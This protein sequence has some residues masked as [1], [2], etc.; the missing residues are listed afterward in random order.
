MTT[1]HRTHIVMY[2]LIMLAWLIP[3]AFPVHAQL[4]PLLGGQRAGI[5]SLQFLK[6][7][8]GARAGAMAE[9]FVAVADDASALQY[10][11]AGLVQFS[12]H[13]IMFSH[14][15]WLV[16]LRHEFIGAVYRLSSADAI[17]VSFISLHTDD[18]E[19]TTET[20]PFGTGRYFSYG[21]IAF[22]L[23][24]SRALTEQFSFG[25]TVRYVE[26]SIDVLKT[27]AFMVDIGTFYRT[28]LGSTR[29]SVV[30]TNFGPNVAPE[31]VVQLPR[32]EELRSFQEFSPPTLFRI[33]FAFEA[34]QDDIN[35]I[36]TSLQ[37]N[38]P[39][40][41][42]E[43][44]ALGVEYAWNEIMH[45]RCGYKLNVDEEGL[46]AG[47]GVLAPVGGVTAGVDYAFAEFGRLGGVHRLTIRLG[48]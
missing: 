32:R 46:T 39:N 8:A 27:R 20:Q 44:L 33:G 43:N 16:D 15:N 31:G 26:E 4:I 6:I 30:V 25:A 40:D 36:T 12:G 37:L 38:H 28:G 41:N 11:P 29:F 23:S 21:D 14:T 18:M 7:G 17:G 24:Y 42:S 47:I 3:A 35:R 9:A 2:V 1:T 22:G 34:L 13:Q 19:V 48:M 5:S 10:N 45:L